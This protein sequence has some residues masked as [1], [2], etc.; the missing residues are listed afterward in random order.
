MLDSIQTK[1]KNLFIEHFTK[2]LGD[3]YV[4]DCIWGF[5]SLQLT[6]ASKDQP[7]KSIWRVTLDVTTK[8]FALETKAFK[9]KEE[10]EVS[11]WTGIDSATI[12]FLINESIKVSNEIFN[13]EK[14]DKSK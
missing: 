10:V 5:P 2:A 7:I 4:I 11:E 12:G 9:L 3:K 8:A 13:V 1:N 6:I 14:A